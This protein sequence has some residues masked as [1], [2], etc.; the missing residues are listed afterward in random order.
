MRDDKKVYRELS[1][2]EQRIIDLVRELNYG[3]LVV[4]VKE[5]Q[6]VRVEIRRSISLKEKN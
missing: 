5:K 3:E 1:P 4:M 2:E 6:P